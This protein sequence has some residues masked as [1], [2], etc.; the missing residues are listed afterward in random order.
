MIFDFYFEAK[1]QQDSAIVLY[2]WS[3]PEEIKN[4]NKGQLKALYGNILL[5][6]KLL[7]ASERLFRGSG[8]IVTTDRNSVAPKTLEHLTQIKTDRVE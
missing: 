6:M 7:I 1:S 2:E 5:K 4:L 8:R 3:H